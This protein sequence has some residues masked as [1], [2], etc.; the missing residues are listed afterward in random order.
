MYAVEFLTGRHTTTNYLRQKCN[1]GYKL[2]NRA[3]YWCGLKFWENEDGIANLL[4]IP[5]LESAGW[6]LDYTDGI[7]TAFS[8][9]GKVLTFKKDTGVCGGMPFI[10][11]NNLHEHVR[12]FR[13][14]ES[15]VCVETVRGQMEGFTKEQVQRATEAR[16]AVAMMAHPPVEKLKRLVST[17]NVIKN[18]PFDAQDLTNS[19][20]IFGKDRGAIRGKT[21]RKKPSRVRPV[22]ISIPRDLYEHIKNVTLAADVMFC[23]GLPFFVTISRDIKLIMVEFL[24]SR[25]VDSLCSKLMKVLKV[26]RRGGF[27]VRTCLMDMEFKPLVDEFEEATINVTAAREHVGDVERAIRFIEE[28]ARSVVSE[29]PYKHCM[30]DQFVV[31]LLYFVTLWIN[32]FPSDSGVSAVYSPREIVTGMKMEYA[33]HCKARFGAYVEAS[34]DPTITN[35]L[36]ARTS[37][38]IVLGPTGNLQGSVKCYNLT[39]KQIVD[40]RVVTPL[41]V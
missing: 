12:G 10:D 19:D 18:I 25:T 30:P 40:R 38:C 8:P 11:M 6:K 36:Q 33:K 31:H 2:T 9:N 39:T 21:T 4:S 34:D 32:A 22:M 17:T 20:I 24:P 23:N 15:L 27:A 13:Q 28:Q 7:W 26:Y 1:V 5:Q 16:N 14:T 41:L 37:P 35:T 29:L 3:G